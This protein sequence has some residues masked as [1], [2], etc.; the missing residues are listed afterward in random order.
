MGSGMLSA[1]LVELNG[2][3]H[4]LLSPDIHACAA[5]IGVID[6]LKRKWYSQL[7]ECSSG[8]VSLCG[9]YACKFQAACTMACT[10]TWCCCLACTMYL[11]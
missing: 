4:C 9:P 6:E 1:T 7:A 10:L 11:R 5:Q 2:R 8:P 3:V